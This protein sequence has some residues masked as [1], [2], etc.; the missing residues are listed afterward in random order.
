MCA[1]G[2]D[3]MQSDPGT[4][5]HLQSCGTVDQLHA[6]RQQLLC[7]QAAMSADAGMEKAGALIKLQF[8]NASAYHEPAVTAIHAR[9][10]DTWMASHQPPAQLRRCVLRCMCMSP[11]AP[12]LPYPCE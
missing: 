7:A 1:K 6:I 8:G 12:C 3:C 4:R 5:S 11:L 2:H 9:S 10:F